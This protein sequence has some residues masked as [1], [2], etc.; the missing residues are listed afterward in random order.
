MEKSN[1]TMAQQV[2]LAASEFQQQCTGHAPQ[3]VIAVL[4]G[5]PW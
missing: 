5:K 3:S 2:A 1:A 4:T